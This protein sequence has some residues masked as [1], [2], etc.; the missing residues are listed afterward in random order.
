[1]RQSHAAWKKSALRDRVKK[2]CSN[3]P[4]EKGV[5]SEY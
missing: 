3:G 2:E 1:M 5:K 4:S